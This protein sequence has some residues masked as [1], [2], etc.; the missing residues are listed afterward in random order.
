MRRS[1]CMKNYWQRNC[2]TDGCRCENSMLL[3]SEI[4]HIRFSNT[5]LQNQVSI[6]IVDSA[7]VLSLRRKDRGCL[8]LCGQP[9]WTTKTAKGS[10]SAGNMGTEGGQDFMEDEEHSTWWC[11]GL[12]HVG[13]KVTTELYHSSLRD[14]SI[15]KQLKLHDNKS[16]IF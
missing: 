6:S 7:R 5:A 13:G 4:K 11:V 1:C 3:I 9:P 14:V 12:T 15:K 2:K 8:Y 10:S 16:N